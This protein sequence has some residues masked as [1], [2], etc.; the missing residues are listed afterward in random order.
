MSKINET[1][2]L[3]ANEGLEIDFSKIEFD[4]V[5]TTKGKFPSN[6]S[7]LRANLSNSEIIA[8][9]KVLSAVKGVACF[10]EDDLEVYL[11][12]WLEYHFNCGVK[13]FRWLWDKYRN[14]KA[15]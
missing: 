3:T 8:N 2:T 5:V 12:K 1:I 13:T 10:T 4:T 14:F 9:V 15:A 6:P 7:W 11:K